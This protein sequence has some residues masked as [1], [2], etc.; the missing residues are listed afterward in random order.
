MPLV[1]IDAEKVR[2]VMENLLSNAAKY[3]RMDGSVTVRIGREG[4]ADSEGGGRA[5]GEGA[6]PDS[7]SGSASGA[8]LDSAPDSASGAAPDFS[9]DSAPDFASGAAPDFSLDSAPCPACFFIEV[10]DCG[11]GIEKDRLDGIFDLFVQGGRLCPPS[12]QRQRGGAVPGQQAGVSARRDDRGGK[13]G[14]RR[15]PFHRASPHFPAR[16]GRGARRGAGEGRGAGT[17]CGIGER[18]GAGM[19]CGAGRGRGTETGH[20]T[21]VC[22]E[23]E[24]EGRKGERS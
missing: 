22:R 24:G 15:E 13:R 14:G 11:I 19:R 10:A 21:G 4:L 5:E 18:R 6:A 17:R 2:M 20:G 7:A 3:S 12:L 16:C 8:A 1:E 9:L 23:P